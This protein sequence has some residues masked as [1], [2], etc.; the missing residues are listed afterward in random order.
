[1]AKD[2][3]FVKVPNEL[4]I[5]I[6]TYGFTQTQMAVV[7]YIVRKTLGWRKRKDKIAISTM[8]KELNKKRQLI[9]RTVSDLQKMTVVGIERGRNGVP[10]I[11]WVQDPEN[12]D[13]PATV[14]FHATTGFHETFYDKTCN[15][16]VSGG[17]TVELQEPATVQFHTTDNT[18]NITDNTTDISPDPTDEDDGWM[19]A[20]EALK[21]WRGS[22]GAV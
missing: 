18:D 6:I 2:D 5:A 13:K 16:T 21:E 11:M 22:N 15:R 1:M 8:A 17:E 4:Y 12:W 7:L 10:P 19:D 20:D 3:G 14:Q 9:S